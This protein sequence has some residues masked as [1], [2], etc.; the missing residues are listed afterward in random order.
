[1]AKTQ[2]AGLPPEV[3]LSILDEIADPKIAASRKAVVDGL[4]QDG[5]D[6]AGI[7]GILEQENKEYNGGWTRDELAGHLADDEGGRLIEAG[8][9]QGG[10][11]S[12]E[13]QLANMLLDKYKSGAGGGSKLPPSSILTKMGP[14]LSPAYKMKLDQINREKERLGGRREYVGDIMAGIAASGSD[15][16]LGSFATSFQKA[17]Q[18]RYQREDKMAELEKREADI[19]FE[20]E[21][22]RIARAYWGDMGKQ[23]GDEEGL[24]EGISLL[25]AI[26]NTGRRGELNE[27]SDIQQDIKRK[28]LGGWDA[29][30]DREER[31]AA[32]S[33]ENIREDNERADQEFEFKKGKQPLADENT[34]NQI[35]DRN[36]RARSAERNTTARIFQSK[37]SSEQKNLEAALDAQEN[38]YS[39]VEKK[40]ARAQVELS[41]KALEKINAE[42][43]DFLTDMEIDDVEMSDEDRAELDEQSDRL[44][45]AGKYPS[46]SAAKKSLIERARGE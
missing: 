37:R 11:G 46:L 33:I 30:Q 24:K 42:E 43:D 7:W 4:K 1:M 22:D 28:E 2:F 15:G 35:E 20:S 5:L 8:P 36:R 27:S 23:V 17:R 32:S 38:A 29:K 12:P 16:P 10:G 41:R 21:S 26:S 9:A 14:D 40:K 6:E 3:D 19:N 34:R 45:K 39:P 31:K 44:F 18:N 13:E 25:N